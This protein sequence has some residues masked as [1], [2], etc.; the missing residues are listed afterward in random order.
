V[1]YFEALK[2]LVGSLLDQRQ[3]QVVE[4]G[5][6][7]GRSLASRLDKLRAGLDCHEPQLRQI[8]LLECWLRNR[9]PAS[10]CEAAARAS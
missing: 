1:P 10:S 6:V 9:W 3:W 5:W 4:R 8:I 7:D 2:P